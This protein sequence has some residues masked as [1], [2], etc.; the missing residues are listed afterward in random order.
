MW[1]R[2]LID[3]GP[4]E[5]VRSASTPSTLHLPPLKPQLLDVIALWTISCFRLR[6]PILGP[7]PAVQGQGVN[8]GSVETLPPVASPPGTL[9]V[10]PLHAPLKGSLSVPSGSG[11]WVNQEFHAAGQPL[12]PP[13]HTV[14]LGKEPLS[15]QV[16]KE[17]LLGK[18][19]SIWRG[20]GPGGQATG[21]TRLHAGQGVLHPACWP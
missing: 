7:I 17:P 14:W 16:R 12:G 19:R 18:P 20:T 2:V 8:P 21:Q 15:I 4:G 5:Q 9:S 6:P 11:P 10:P 13:T 1:S 3:P